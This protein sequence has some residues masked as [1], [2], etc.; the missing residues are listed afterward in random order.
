MQATCHRILQLPTYQPSS[1]VDD[2]AQQQH[3]QN[4]EMECRA[5][6]PEEVPPHRHQLTGRLEHFLLRI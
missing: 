3:G 5:S 6:V 1:I 4:I 2:L